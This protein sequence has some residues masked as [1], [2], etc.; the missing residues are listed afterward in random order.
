[1]KINHSTLFY[2]FILPQRSKI[3]NKAVIFS[4]NLAK[5]SPKM[6][7]YRLLKLA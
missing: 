5:Y 6:T 4:E 3:H 7:A 1:M 2:T